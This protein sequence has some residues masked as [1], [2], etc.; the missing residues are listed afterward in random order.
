MVG[1]RGRVPS[2][3]FRL[4]PATLSPASRRG[5]LF[6]SNVI[7]VIAFN[8]VMV[9]LGIAVASQVVPE[10]MLSNMLGYLHTT[11]GITT[12]PPERVRIVVLIWL[13][14]MLILVDGLL[15][16]LVFLMSE[17]H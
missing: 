12:P 17:I 7:G 3:S 16:L 15:F 14:S 1:R 6:H 13:G 2:C 5:F 10:K 4:L 11:I 9:L 8:I